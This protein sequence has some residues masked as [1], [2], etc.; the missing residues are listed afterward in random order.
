MRQRQGVNTL[1]SRKARELTGMSSCIGLAPLTRRFRR[2][3][4]RV[5]RCAG[6]CHTW[7][8]VSNGEGSLR[9]MGSSD[10]EEREGKPVLLRAR[11]QGVSGGVK[12]SEFHD[13]AAV[14]RRRRVTAAVLAT[15]GA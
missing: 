13:C 2:V 9:E 11:R 10:S 5:S 15:V 3:Y 12:R 14:A 1:S 7:L 6:C 8:F 4:K